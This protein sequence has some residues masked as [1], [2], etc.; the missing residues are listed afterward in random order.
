MI[1][2]NSKTGGC[3][4]KVRGGIF[5]RFFLWW[6]YTFGLHPVVLNM[7]MKI[8][9]LRFKYTQEKNHYLVKHDRLCFWRKP[10]VIGRWF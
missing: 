7:K 6:D 9:K 10:K 2:K 5:W 8:W 4:I 1:P 3:Y